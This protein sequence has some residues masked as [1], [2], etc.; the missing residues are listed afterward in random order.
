MEIDV[1]DRWLANHKSRSSTTLA[2]GGRAVGTHDLHTGPGWQFAEI[3]II[4]EPS[5]ELRVTVELPDDQRRLLDS[6]DFVDQAIFGLLDILATAKALPVFG[7]HIRLVRAKL[8][9]VRSSK[10]AFRMAGRD[11]ASKLLAEGGT[12]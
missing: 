11:A 3:E 9:A 1:L 12:K 8:D 7:V 2:R 5:S 10:V 6:G 4:A